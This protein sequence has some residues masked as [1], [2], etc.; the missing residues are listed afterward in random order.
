[1]STEVTFWNS[2]EHGI[3]DGSDLNSAEFRGIFNANFCGIPR[4]VAEFR[5]LFYAEV[6]MSCGFFARKEVFK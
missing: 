5:V 6:R 2:A 4:T 3:F 1:V